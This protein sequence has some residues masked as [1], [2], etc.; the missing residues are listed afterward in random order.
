M[1]EQVQMDTPTLF[2][3]I[4]YNDAELIDSLLSIQIRN[5]E[6]SGLDPRTHALVRLAALVSIDA[7]PASFNWQVA[8]AK[9]SGVSDAEI[10][11]VLVALAP[12]IGMAKV[13]A[14][15]PEVANALGIMVEE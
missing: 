9:S 2:K 11:G 8:L 1:A 6:N 3:R 15:A 10:L 7:A 14:A 4:A 5:I 13:V 12:T